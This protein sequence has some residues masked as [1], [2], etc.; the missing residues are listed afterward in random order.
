MLI[1]CKLY[2][3]I[4]N[5]FLKFLNQLKYQGINLVFKE[6]TVKAFGTDE[7]TSSMGRVF[8][9]KNEVWS[10]WDDIFSLL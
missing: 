2:N 8:E 10:I 5:N 6:N 9:V 3:N 4:L 1:F 7:V